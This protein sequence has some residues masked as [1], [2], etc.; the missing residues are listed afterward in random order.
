MQN[1]PETVKHLLIINVIFFLATLVLGDIVYDLF[2]L[3]YPSNPKFEFWQPLTH[4]FM[5]GDFSHIFFNMFGLYMFGT[6]IEQMWGRKKFIFFYLSTGFGA[7]ALQLGL[8]Y[9][10]VTQVLDLLAA[11]GLSGSQIATFFETR[12][13]SYSIIEQ[14]GREALLEGLSTF[15]S[16]MVGASGALYGV[17]VAFAFLFPNARLMLLFPPI[18]VKAK[19]LV[20]ILIF[21][22]LFFG[23][24]SY[25]IGPIAHFAH[26]GG[27]ITGLI[28]LWYWKKTQFD[29]NRW[30]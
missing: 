14:I 4:M 18:P 25:S 7:A 10:Q 29:Q 15:N 23:F 6:P 16:V 12:D 28:M 21:G 11:Q 9:Y 3:H 20:P 17:L 22:D 27:A 8:Y 19:V 30:N 5:H 24:T 13:L 2:A 1:I 26:V